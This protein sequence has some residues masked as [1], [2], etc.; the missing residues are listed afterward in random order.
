[1]KMIVL[2]DWSDDQKGMPEKPGCTEE[3]CKR[4]RRVMRSFE[5]WRRRQSESHRL[6]LW[7]T[8]FPWRFT[9]PAKHAK[10]APLPPDCEAN[11]FAKMVEAVAKNY[12]PDEPIFVAD[13][14]FVFTD[15]LDLE[16]FVAQAMQ[17]NSGVVMV[18]N[19]WILSPKM[20]R[21]IGNLDGAP[22]SVSSED[23][24][25]EADWT[26]ADFL[27]WV[28]RTTWTFAKTYAETAPHEYAVL[29][30]PNTELRDLYMATMFILRN[31]FVQMFY[32]TPFMSYEVA[33][34]RYWSYSS[35]DLVNR[36]LEG[37]LKTYS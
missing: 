37:D 32:N 36:T 19:A 11:L 16:P 30:K 7:H 25:F 35:Y 34:R 17:P 21:L 29:G 6:V 5:F 14:S 1:M 8:H 18:N 33:N 13:D 27:D 26:E 9:P 23:V 22:H 12:S 10:D 4:G 31:G 2:V 15:D 3:A 20:Q 28:G 24:A